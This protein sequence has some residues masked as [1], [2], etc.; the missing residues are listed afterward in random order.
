MVSRATFKTTE[1]FA[2][3]LQFGS[4]AITIS[5]PH[6]HQTY[7][8]GDLIIIIGETNPNNLLNLEL[9]RP[10]GILVRHVVTYSNSDGRISDLTFRV[11]PNPMEGEWI[12][13]ASSG[14]NSVEVPLTVL[15]ALEDGMAVS[16]THEDDTINDGD[17]IEINIVGASV[18]SSA[19]T[20]ITDPTGAE[21]EQL[22][23]KITDAGIAH[24]LWKVPDDSISGT[25]TVT[26]TVNKD[27]ATT[28]FVIN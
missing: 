1:M 4:G 8:G 28:T 20:T 14:S 17:L 6:D 11:P 18:Q 22:K 27:V 12:L 3:G 19:V 21:L 24:Q 23:T 26:V 10:D 2:V 15:S 25:Y 7:V 13:K 9:I 5:H 16:V